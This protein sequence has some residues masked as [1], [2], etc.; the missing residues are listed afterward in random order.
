MSGKR[1]NALTLFS[2]WLFDASILI[3]RRVGGTH[4][5]CTRRSSRA[6]VH[7]TGCMSTA[8]EVFGS[9]AGSG[10]TGALVVGDL[11]VS[12]PAPAPLLLAPRT[13]R[14]RVAS[15]G[16]R[17]TKKKNSF[18]FQ[19]TRTLAHMSAVGTIFRK[20]LFFSF[21]TRQNMNR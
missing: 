7:T 2:R 4:T 14:P 12:A 9:A 21:F 19:R 18:I 1:E 16:K 8:A 11:M 17:K 10:V 13:P 3:R 5:Y 15:E 6:R 20:I